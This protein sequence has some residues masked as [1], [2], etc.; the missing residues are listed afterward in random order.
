[1]LSWW[2]VT[3]CNNFASWTLIIAQNMQETFI[4]F[5][6]TF[7]FILAGLNYMPSV[8]WRCW[9]GG[10]KGIQPV[11]NWVVGCWRGCL[12]V[13]RCIW[14]SWCHCHSLSLASV[15]SRMVFT[16]LVPAHPSSPGQRAV[17]RACVWTTDIKKI[18][19]KSIYFTFMFFYVKWVDGFTLTGC[20]G[21]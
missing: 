17:K 20:W 12:S 13:L 21:H 15:K 7:Y 6:F 10:K 8:L 14:L 4:L 5:Y 16:F 19:K 18:L 1:M 3:G 9:L 11:K 2:D